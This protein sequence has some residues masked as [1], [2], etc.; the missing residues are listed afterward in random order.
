MNELP[1]ERATSPDFEFESLRAAANY[2]CALVR[3]FKPHLHG[4]VLE[5]GAGIG[6]ISELLGK[7]SAV[8]EMLCVEPDAKF[9][10]EFRRLWPNQ[11]LLEGTV[12]SLTDPRPWN[13]VVSIN[14]LEHI[15]DDERELAAYARLLRAEHGNLCL[16][17][18][19]RPEIY[20]PLDADFG[21][22]RR[23]TKPELK[24]KFERA[25]FEIVRLNYFNLI[26]YFAWW[27]KFCLLKQRG[28]DVGSV[29]FF[30]RVVFPG[31]Y[32]MESRLCAPPFGQS[33]I[34]VA[35]AK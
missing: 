19:A 26:G 29:R 32:W 12:S 4:R 9:C 34:A 5:V 16:F 11:P 20:A 21:H 2:R 8:S 10:A 15:R 31:V 13:G 23:Y 27:F 24:R 3:E 35:R 33:L 1:N 14:V 28:F 6:Q 17:V 25:G 18:P 30:D 7:I 22:H